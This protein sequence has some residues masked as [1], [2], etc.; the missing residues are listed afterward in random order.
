MSAVPADATAAIELRNVFGGY[1]PLRILNGVDLAVRSRTITTLAAPTGAGKRPALQAIFGPAD[2][3]SGT[4][5]PTRRPM[6]GQWRRVWRARTVKAVHHR[7][8]AGSSACALR[9]PMTGDTIPKYGEF[10]K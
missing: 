3:P 9:R 10:A 1:G 2:L 6:T 8:A 7:P 5:P 4:V